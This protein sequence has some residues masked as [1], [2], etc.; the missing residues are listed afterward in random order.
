MPM[1]AGDI[2][3]LI[4]LGDDIAMQWYVLS[5]P[6]TELPAPAPGGQIEIP[7]IARA[8]FNPNLIIVGLIIVA[9]IV[10]LK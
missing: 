10:V 6:G 3:N 7:G 4:M 8:S 9:A 5:H 2:G 1:D